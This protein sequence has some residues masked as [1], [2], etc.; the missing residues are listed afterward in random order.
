METINLY[1]YIV[2]AEIDG[3]TIR[4]GISAENDDQF[5]NEGS[6]AIYKDVIL[7][8]LTKECNDPMLLMC[9]ETEIR[10]RKPLVKPIMEGY[11]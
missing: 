6:I 1:R 3:D 4:F 11:N 2:Y 7:H 8:H 10:Q 9:I 5:S